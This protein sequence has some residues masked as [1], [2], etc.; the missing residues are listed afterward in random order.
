MECIPLS[1]QKIK[2]W[3]HMDV[4]YIHGSESPKVRRFGDTGPL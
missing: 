3:E 2:Q 1:G 4:G